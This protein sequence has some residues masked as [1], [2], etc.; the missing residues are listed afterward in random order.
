MSS[1]FMPLPRSSMI[2]ESSSGD[3]LLCF[4]AGESELCGGMVRFPP[5]VKAGTPIP[6]LGTPGRGPP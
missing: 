1:H 4:L 3:H 2:S 5:V 6:T